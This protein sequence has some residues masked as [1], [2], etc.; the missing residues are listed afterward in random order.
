[1]PK[2]GRAPAPNPDTGILIPLYIYPG[3]KWEEVIEIARANPKV[4]IVAIINPDSGPGT[5]VDPNYSAGISGLKSA[6]VAVLGYTWT[7]YASRG[8]SDVKSS[9]RAYKDWYDV[10]GIFLDEMSNL[11]GKEAYYS[12]LDDYARSLGLGFTIGNPGTDVPASYIGA[13]DTLVI[14][15]GPGFPD[16]SN[17][18]NRHSNQNKANFAMIA[19]GVRNIDLSSISAAAPSV[20]YVYVTDAGLP[21]PYGV[22]PPYLSSIA[23]ALAAGIGTSGRGDGFSAKAARAVRRLRQGMD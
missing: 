15:E 19:Y 18:R 4:P 20:G 6:G 12:V 1:M 17:L 7:D 21:N 2:V 10:N 22:L 5:R 14:H 8:V 13:V 23:A 3:P 11:P 16:L 9:I